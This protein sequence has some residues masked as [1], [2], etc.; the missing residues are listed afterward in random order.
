MTQ[1]LDAGWW[2]GCVDLF[3]RRQPIARSGNVAIGASPTIPISNAKWHITDAGG[4]AEQQ[5]DRCEPPPARRRCVLEGC[6]PILA[7]A[8]GRGALGQTPYPQGRS[9]PH[10]PVAGFGHSL[11]IAPDHHPHRRPV[12]PSHGGPPIGYKTRRYVLPVSTRFT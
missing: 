5:F 8:G 9:A 3:P 2:I 12:R 1:A 11:G 7:V 6:L 4:K 10:G